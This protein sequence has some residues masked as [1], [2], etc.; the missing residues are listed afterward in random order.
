MVWHGHVR[1]PCPWTH[2]RRKQSVER[3]EGGRRLEGNNGHMVCT[4]ISFGCL[5]CV[6]WLYVMWWDFKGFSCLTRGN[7]SS[8]STG[9]NG[10]GQRQKKKRTVCGLIDYPTVEKGNDLK[11]CQTLKQYWSETVGA[12]VRVKRRLDNMAINHPRKHLS[13]LLY[14]ITA[15]SLFQS[16]PHNERHSLL[17]LGRD[18]LSR[19]TESYRGY[20]FLLSHDP[21]TQGPGSRSPAG[22][23]KLPGGRRVAALLH[24]SDR[25]P[26]RQEASLTGI[27]DEGKPKLHG[28]IRPFALP[29]SLGSDERLNSVVL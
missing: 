26:S 16:W 1:C 9:E 17:E 25:T 14:R 11:L 29:F 4:S 18:I 22:G 13:E 7:F 12:C 21:T 3:L 23:G 6:I 20:L 27:A 10:T 5:R 15:A 8:C 24:C 28:T 2:L 19:Q